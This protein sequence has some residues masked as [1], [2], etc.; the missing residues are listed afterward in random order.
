VFASM[1]FCLR[2]PNARK[3]SKQICDKEP[4]VPTLSSS[5]NQGYGA[6]TGNI[7]H[8]KARDARAA[9]RPRMG[10]FLAPASVPAEGQGLGAHSDPKGV[11]W[12]RRRWLFP[13]E[14]IS[15]F[16]KCEIS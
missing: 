13:H 11:G 4:N 5:K 6:G 7:Y 12:G 10:A 15:Q 14:V 9:S 8:S 3:S 1:R 16:E 2:S